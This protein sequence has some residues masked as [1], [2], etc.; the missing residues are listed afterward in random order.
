MMFWGTPFLTF[1]RRRVL[2]AF[3]FLSVLSFSNAHASL[4]ANDVNPLLRSGRSDEAISNINEALKTSPKDYNLIFLKAVILAGRNNVA[5]AQQLFKQLSVE[6]PDRPEPLNNLAVLLAREGRFD[7]ARSLLDRAMLTDPK[8]A[9]IQ[10][11]IGDLNAKLA[12]QAYNKALKKNTTIQSAQLSFLRD[13]A[14]QAIL[15]PVTLAPVTLAQ[16]TVTQNTVIEPL[17]N[18][19]VKGSVVKTAPS[20]PTL[21]EKPITAEVPAPLKDP[22]NETVAPARSDRLEKSV[23][24]ATQKWAQAWSARDVDQYLAYYDKQ[25]SGKEQSRSVWEGDRRNKILGKK[26][27]QVDVQMPKM[28]ISGARA[29]VSFSQIY[30]AD[31]LNIRS[32]KTLVWVQQ[33]NSWVIVDE[34]AR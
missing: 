19:V 12:S 29:T 11:N 10:R 25:F 32:R 22:K 3:I 1:S 31:A 14:G 24:D 2:R 21:T 26:R 16:N 6:F 18:P 4:T 28:S 20:A 30:R 5:E 9:Q 7:E 8:Y 13:L 33:G 23:L 15:A 17:P 34:R 27:I